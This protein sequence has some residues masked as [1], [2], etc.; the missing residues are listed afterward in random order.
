MKKLLLSLFIGLTGVLTM[1]QSPYYENV[2]NGRETLIERIRTRFIRFGD[3]ST[4]TKGEFLYKTTIDSS[5]FYNGDSIALVPNVSN[6]K[7]LINYMT[8]DLKQNTTAYT[9]TGTDSILVYSY[10]GG[11]ETIL[12]YVTDGFI[13]DNVNKAPTMIGDNCVDENSPI[14]IIIPGQY[15]LGDTELEILTSISYK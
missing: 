1:A 13:T 10:C 3:G 6:K 5:S 12:Y 4:L 9:S 7:L 2:G 14:W 15:T 11:E 8:F